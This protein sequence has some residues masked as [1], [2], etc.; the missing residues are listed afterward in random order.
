ML[1]YNSGAM[2][3][4]LA[5]SRLAAASAGRPPAIDANRAGLP[6][7]LLAY[8]LDS[9]VLFAFTM[10]FAA[11]AGGNMY[12]S[13]H[14]GDRAIT[15]SAEWTS[16]GIFIAAMPAWLILMVVLSVLRGQTPG[17][18]VL[19]LRIVAEDGSKPSPGRLTVYWL[20]LHPLVFHP[21]FGG[22]WVVL[23]WA[24]LLSQAVFLLSLALAI[25]C[26]VAP[27]ASL[28]F[29]VIDRQHR[30]IPDR[31]AGLKVVRLE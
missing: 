31:L 1:G 18:F 5:A 23:A 10:L 28:I 17:Q 3:E 8:V 22:G 16:I 15:D 30:T 14:G 12:L 2:A 11:M 29:A 4:Q 21:M 7:R 20:A 9:I 24:A 19:G 25:L 27:L 13:T 26:F 6:T